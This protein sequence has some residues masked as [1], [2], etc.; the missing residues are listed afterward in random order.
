M[1]LR[2]FSVFVVMAATLTACGPSLEWR[3]LPLQELGLEASLPCKPDRAERGV[4]LGGQT[5]QVVMQGCEA[6]GTTFAVACAALSEPAGAGAALAH[7]RAAVLAAAQAQG[8]KD[9]PFQPTGALGLPQAMRTSATGVLPG[10]GSMQMQGA[11]FARVQG[12]KVHVCHAMVYG[13]ELPAATADVFFEALVL[14]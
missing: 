10:G 7:W 14:R 1:T 13:S 4:E 6:A 2:L 5:V 12:G 11:W 3:T 8:A 9:R